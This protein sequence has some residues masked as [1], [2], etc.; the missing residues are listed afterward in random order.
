MGGAATLYLDGGEE[1]SGAVLSTRPAVTTSMYTARAPS[2]WNNGTAD[3]VFFGEIT[4]TAITDTALTASEILAYISPPPP[5]ATPPPSPPARPP[6]VESEASIGG[7]PH[8]RGGHGDIFHL[9]GD[10]KRPLCILSAANTSLNALFVNVTYRAAYSKRTVHGSFIKA[11]F[12]SIRLRTGRLL[13]VEFRN[14]VA[15]VR[16]QGRPTFLRMLKHG[17][18]PFSVEGLSVSVTRRVPWHTCTVRTQQWSMRARSTWWEPHKGIVRL[19]LHVQPL[20]ANVERRVAPH[21]ILGQTFDGDG[22]PL[23]GEVDDYRRRSAVMRTS[24]QGRGAIEGSVADYRVA[25]PFATNFR[26]SRFDSIAAR[27]RDASRLRHANLLHK[28]RFIVTEPTL[29]NTT[30]VVWRGVAVGQDAKPPRA[31]TKAE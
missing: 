4:Y 27:P 31:S 29:D 20:V 1:S 12:W 2:I 6:P 28:N 18:P 21:G 13:R 11:A 30:L 22:R 7:D 14:T 5:P 25:T 9:R 15:V 3:Q 16:E 8:V 17:A 24:A 23:H 10:G 19:S 26:F